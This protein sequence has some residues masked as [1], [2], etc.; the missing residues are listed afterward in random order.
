MV[1]PTGCTR[2]VG[3][4]WCIKCISFAFQNRLTELFS[5]ADDKTFDKTVSTIFSHK[6]TFL[7]IYF[8]F[9]KYHLSIYVHHKLLL[10]TNNQLK[11][12]KIDLFS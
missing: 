9:S 3:N 4:D 7:P 8:T 6:S 1:V 10:I 11:V 5:H 2:S 12:I